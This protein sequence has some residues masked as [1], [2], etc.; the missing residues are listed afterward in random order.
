MKDEIL[1]F[2]PPP[3]MTRFD[4]RLW[5]AC[6]LTFGVLTKVSAAA[7]ASEASAQAVRGLLQTL[8]EELPN[9]ADRAAG[10]RLITV[11]DLHGAVWSQPDS[12][13]I[14]LTFNRDGVLTAVQINASSF[15]A[16]PPLIQRAV[17]VHEV[18][19]VK[20]A[21]ETAAQ[22]RHSAGPGPSGERM[23]R[24]V[25]AVVDD[26][27]RAYRKDILYVS[28]AVRSHGGLPAYLQTLPPPHRRLMQRYYHEAVEPFVAP[29]GTV[30]ER[31]LRR[32]GIFF[33]TFPHRYPRYYEAA[34]AW[35]ALHGH[36]EIRRGSDGILRPTR[37]LEPAAFLTWLSL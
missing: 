7:P 25:R 20:R 23:H 31:R 29:D 15:L 16:A 9:P 11:F 5:L 22:L 6:L 36:V 19:H 14:V 1:S 12:E 35:E 24:I 21:P 27:C 26:E 28:R 33:G 37:L 34:L 8:V 17:M 4:V 10:E 13:W 18:E 2:S 3:D 30:N 32:D